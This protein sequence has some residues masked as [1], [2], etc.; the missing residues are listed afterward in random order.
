MIVMERVEWTLKNSILNRNMFYQHNNLIFF[1]IEHFGKLGRGFSIFQN[2][3]DQRFDNSV[4]VG[5]S[6][7]K[8]WHSVQISICFKLK[9]FFSLKID[10]IRFLDW[11]VFWSNEVKKL[12]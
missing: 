9:H 12:Y 3:K 8:F 6:L 11:R 2:N 7:V 5:L 1:Y 10:T 4:A